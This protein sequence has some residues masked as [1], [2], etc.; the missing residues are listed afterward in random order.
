ML[1]VEIIGHLYGHITIDYKTMALVR[2]S[3]VIQSNSKF[4]LP[5]SL[6]RR[7]N[8]QCLERLCDVIY[9]CIPAFFFQDSEGF[10]RNRI[11]HH[12]QVSDANVAMKIPF[13]EQ[14][15]PPY[16]HVRQV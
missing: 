6:S 16:Q 4:I 14:V 3:Q 15:E 12:D 7:I 11:I 13:L 8:F 5:S 10:R 2:D 1:L 9:C